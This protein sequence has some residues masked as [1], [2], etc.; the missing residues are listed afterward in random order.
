MKIGHAPVKE[1]EGL[2]RWINIGL[3]SINFLKENS[4]I[5]NKKKGRFPKKTSFL[6]IGKKA[7]T[8]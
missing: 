2:F 5:F 4:H 8:N 6:R 3:F 1:V 7:T